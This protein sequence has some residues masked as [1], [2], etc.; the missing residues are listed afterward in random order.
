MSR[1]ERDYEPDSMTAPVIHDFCPFEVN[2]GERFFYSLAEILWE[3]R[4]LLPWSSPACP[5]I[6]WVKLPDYHV[7]GVKADIR[8]ELN[9]P[10]KRSTI[11][12]HPGLNEQAQW[13]SLCG[14]LMSS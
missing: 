5:G 11:P 10:Q 12:Y 13:S 7:V 8:T 14:M 4:E 9:A 2:A 1:I 6:L 3:M